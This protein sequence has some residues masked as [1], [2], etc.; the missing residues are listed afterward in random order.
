MIK[1]FQE[2]L[3]YNITYEKDEHIYCHGLHIKKLPKLPNIKHLICSYNE[4]EDL[5]DIP[6]M[7][8]SLNCTN[9]LLKSFLYIPCNL[10]ELNCCFN[11]LENLPELPKTLKYLRCDQNKLENLPNLPEGLIELSC[12]NNNL[13]KIPKL[14]NNIKHL[15]V[16]NNQLTELYIDSPNIQIIFC[17]N[18]NIKGIYIKHYDHFNHKIILKCNN[19]PLLYLP[20][21]ISFVSSLN[22]TMSNESSYYNE[23]DKIELRKNQIKLKILKRRVVKN[24]Y[25]DAIDIFL[26]MNEMNNYIIS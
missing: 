13:L 26:M 20:T 8:E 15:F 24:I 1:N 23:L 11:N 14:G 10:V 21:D 16:Y 25:Y 2:L 7:L 19:N 5:D 18:N 12:S 17:E 6:D 3:K 9:N 4:I 22:R